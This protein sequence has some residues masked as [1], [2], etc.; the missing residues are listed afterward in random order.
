MKPIRW[1]R[2]SRKDLV[3]FPDDA[4]SEAGHGLYQVQCGDRPDSEKPLSG[5]L[6]G[7]CELVIDSE[8]G[9]TY[10]SVYTVKMDP[11]VYVLHCFQKKAKRGISTPKHEL[12][13]I[14]KRLKEAKE[15][16]REYQKSQAKKK[17]DS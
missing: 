8:D 12:D 10:R 7:V 13:T 14:R 1:V 9:N 2:S 17:T 15:D 4:R 11:F 16:Y 6:S 3:E 5:D